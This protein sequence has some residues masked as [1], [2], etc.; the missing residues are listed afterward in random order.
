MNGMM[1]SIT[2]LAHYDSRSHSTGTYL[3]ICVLA[4]V[5]DIESDIESVYLIC[6]ISLHI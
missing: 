3:L 4:A 2:K 6:R 5:H 1:T